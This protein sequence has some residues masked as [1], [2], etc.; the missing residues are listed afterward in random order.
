MYGVKGKVGLLCIC[1]VV[2]GFGLWLNLGL[3]VATEKKKKCPHNALIVTNL[4]FAVVLSISKNFDE[5]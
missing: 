1:R 4:A 5:H 3:Y 2:V